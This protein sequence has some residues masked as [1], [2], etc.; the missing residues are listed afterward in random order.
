MRWLRPVVREPLVHFA[1]L[2]GLLFLIFG[3]GE[4]EPSAEQIV[5]SEGQVRNLAA[6]FER[7][8]QRPPTE[9]EVEG[10][11]QDRIDEEVLAREARSLGLDQNDTVIRRR[12]RQK[13]EFVA[14]DLMQRE[15]PDD[16]EL[17]AYLDANPERFRRPGRVSFTQVF[18]D[19]DLRGDGLEQ[20]AERLLVR[21][22][23]GD[24]VDPRRLADPSLLAPSYDLMT[25]DEVDRLFGPEFAER[26]KSLPTGR[27]VGP[28]ASPYGDHLI[29]IE[30]RSAPAPARLDQVRAEV[31]RE[32][33]AERRREAQDAL[34]EEMRRRYEVVVERPDAGLTASGRAADR[35]Q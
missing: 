14:A 17:Q 1:V 2:G 12:L 5:I 8:W 19:R 18:L 10:L 16:A 27:W 3:P 34:L 24:P 26:L 9:A 22:Q 23:A 31:A 13:M 7:T 11:I 29:R 32:L 6:V 20:D 35:V 30:E 21:L 15:P 28:V 4:D 25:T 33:E